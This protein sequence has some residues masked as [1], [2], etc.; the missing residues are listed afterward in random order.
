M[1]FRNESKR[2]YIEHYGSRNLSKRRYKKRYNR[3]RSYSDA[4]FPSSS[5]PSKTDD[6]HLWKLNVYKFKMYLIVQALENYFKKHFGRN[7][8]HFGSGPSLS[9]FYRKMRKHYES[10]N[11]GNRYTITSV[12][13]KRIFTHARLFAVK[14]VMDKKSNEESIEVGEKLLADVRELLNE[15]GFNDL[16]NQINH[17]WN[18]QDL[19]LNFLQFAHDFDEELSKDLL[20]K[21]CDEYHNYLKHLDVDKLRQR[22]EGIIGDSAKSLAN[23]DIK[24]AERE[25]HQREADRQLIN[26]KVN[27]AKQESQ[28]S[29]KSAGQTPVRHKYPRSEVVRLGDTERISS[30]AFLPQQLNRSLRYLLRNDNR[31]D[32]KEIIESFIDNDEKLSVLNY[33]LQAKNV[34]NIKQIVN[35]VQQLRDLKQSIK[36]SR[37]VRRGRKSWKR[38]MCENVARVR[39]IRLLNA[40]IKKYEKQLARIDEII[41][42]QN[43]M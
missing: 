15:T 38:K 36:E 18:H 34:Q 12:D 6:E 29:S 33:N 40:K 13:F 35:I 42:L 24:T 14:E 43:Y 25:L 3:L 19:K 27:A 16:A 10:A 22:I 30:E 2:K 7:E 8:I 21:I 9:S 26:G 31:Q 1:L 41:Q 37:G 32:V 28:T 39:K 11:V 5:I 20:N 17:V 4:V 23:E